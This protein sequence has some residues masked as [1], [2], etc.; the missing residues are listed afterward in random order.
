M[1]QKIIP[2]SLRLN[3]KKNWHSQ[4]F[5]NKLEYS[6]LLFFDF[7]IRKYFFNLFNYRSFKLIK[8][9]II[10]T[11]KNINIYLYTHQIPPYKRTINFHKILTKLN[12]FYSKHYIKL[13]IHRVKPFQVNIFKK[14]IKKIFYFIQKTNRM[15]KNLKKMVFIF[16]YAFYTKNIH[17][18]SEYIKSSLARKKTH[19]KIINSINRVL[20]TYFFL[21]SNLLGYRLQIKGR[22][23]GVKRKKKFICQKGKIPLNSLKHNIKYHFNE[24][25]TPS[26]ICSI[27]FWVFFK[28][29]KRKVNV[30]KMP[31]KPVFQYQRNRIRHIK[32][33][34]PKKNN[35]LY[36]RYKQ[37]KYQQNKNRT[38]NMS[39][40]KNQRTYKKNAKF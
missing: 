33:Q 19:K 31:I 37:Q 29:I 39:L 10:K 23:N 35:L 4:W 13:F 18:I 15:N 2:I 1:G 38:N 28:P 14:V 7:E 24:F 5:V 32:Y 30:Y 8:F 20:E 16:T 3:K 26:G 9:N 17:L 25:K 34:I 6:N 11:S 40:I 12:L 36:P 22:I 21:F 27:K